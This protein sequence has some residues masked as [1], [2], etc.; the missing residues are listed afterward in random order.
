MKR[1]ASSIAILACIVLLHGFILGVAS[2]GAYQPGGGIFALYDDKMGIPA[3]VYSNSNIDGVTFRYMWN[4]IQPQPDS[5][6]WAKIDADISAAHRYG[7]KIS[8]IIVPGVH[9]PSWVY[10]AGATSFAV[11]WDRPFGGFPECSQQR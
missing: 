4:D 9:T 2:S 6:N 8:L 10:A 5:F 1:I 11:V 3:Q 7:K